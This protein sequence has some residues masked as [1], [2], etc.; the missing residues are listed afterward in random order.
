M[1]SAT[2]TPLAP[3]QAAHTASTRA[4][5]AARSAFGGGVCARAE[6][7]RRAR[8]LP[9]QWIAF[10]ASLPTGLAPVARRVWT[11]GDNRST[12]GG[13]RANLNAASAAA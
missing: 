5:P 2:L 7:E 6:Q 8:A 9:A 12:F 11:S 4:L 3:W 1:L 10:I 13:A